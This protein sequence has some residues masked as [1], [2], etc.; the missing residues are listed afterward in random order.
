MSRRGWRRQEPLDERLVAEQPRLLKR[1]FE[2]LV[3]EGIKTPDQILTDLALNPADIEALACLEQGYLSGE[4][5]DV[6][7]MPQLRQEL[8]TNT[9]TGNVIRFRKN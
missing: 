5:P 7:A 3:N 8:R 6:A 4:A 1:G 9:G 2:L